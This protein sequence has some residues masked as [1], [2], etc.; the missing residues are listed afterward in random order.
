MMGDNTQAR[1]VFLATLGTALRDTPKAAVDD[2]LAD[3]AAH[4]SEGVAQGRSEQ[5]IATSLGDPLTLADELRVSVRIDAWQTK[6]SIASGAQ[7][8][9]SA[10]AIGVFN[11]ALTFVLVPLLALIGFATT[12]LIVALAMAGLWLLFAGAALGLPGGA[13]AAALAGIGAIAAAISLAAF[14][15]LSTITLLDAAARY[16]RRHF[17]RQLVPNSDGARS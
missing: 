7:F 10:L 4:F 14:L 5:E 11:A 15:I 3:Y 17:W 8:M 13:W 2:I 6:R 12:V 16:A 9:E 1:A